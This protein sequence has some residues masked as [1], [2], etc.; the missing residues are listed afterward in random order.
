MAV[1]VA[2]RRQTPE[3]TGRALFWIAHELPKSPCEVAQRRAVVPPPNF[4][5]RPADHASHDRAVARVRCGLTP[6]GLLEVAAP[7]AP[8]VAMQVA[9]IEGE[10]A[11]HRRPFP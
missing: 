5:H 8:R 7:E 1:Q 2:L 10:H 6:L 9:G 3:K 4:L 11:P